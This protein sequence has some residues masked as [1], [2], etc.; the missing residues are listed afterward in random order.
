MS[1]RLLKRLSSCFNRR[2]V[3]NFRGSARAAGLEVMQVL[4]VRQMLTAP[5]LDTLYDVTLAED[6]AERSVDLTG[7]TAG[8]GEVQPLRVTALSGNTSLIAAPAIDYTTPN[9]TGTLRFTPVANQHGS[10]TITVKVED[11]GPDLDLA[12]AADNETFSRTFN[13]TVT[14]VNDLP[15]LNPLSDV[16]LNEEAPQQTVSLSGISAGGGEIQPLR[17][18]AT[19]SNPDLI[20]NPSKTY[21]SPQTT[22]SIRVTPAANR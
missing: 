5:T 14:P 22:G 7:I 3:R 9:S 6:A 19:S 2:S 8:A 15:T 18:L 11:G 17:V 21:T 10:T 1:K 12:T 20:P 13:V 4:E 16:T